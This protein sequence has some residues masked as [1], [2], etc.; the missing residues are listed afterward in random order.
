MDQA[1]YEARKDM[2]FFSHKLQKHG[3]VSATD[4]NLSIKLGEDRILITPSSL[5]KEDMTIDAP[6]IIDMQGNLV[7][8]KKRPS[9]EFKVH[10][11]VYAQ[12]EDIHAVIHAHPPKT[13]AFTVANVVPDTCILPEVVVKLGSVPVAP[14]ATPSTD[15]LPSSMRMLIRSSDVVLLAR[16]GSVTA[17]KDL[18]DAFIKVE[19]LEHNSEILMY[20]YILG[21]PK[22]FSSGDIEEL[23]RLRDFYGVKNTTI[24]CAV[25]PGS[26]TGSNK[27]DNGIDIEKLV[28]VIVD[29]VKN[30]LQ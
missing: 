6:V 10:T 2:V 4:G 21:G 29:K 20:T 23:Q 19:K 22:A 30:K 25:H 16:H 15:D 1:E 27:K 3:L 9:T 28:D 5:R 7:D 13:I 18:N 24:S 17:G 12:R 26:N 8:G 11:E 14:Y